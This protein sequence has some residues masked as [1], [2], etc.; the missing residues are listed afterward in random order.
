MTKSLIKDI[1]C[2]LDGKENELW[3]GL[4]RISNCLGV[5]AQHLKC[6]KEQ[7]AQYYVYNLGI[8]VVFMLLDTGQ[9]SD[10]DELAD[11]ECFHEE[12][13]LYF[14]SKSHRPSPVFKLWQK[15]QQCP[16]INGGTVLGV[17]LTNSY[18]INYD[19][20]VKVWDKMH[21]RVRHNLKQQPKELPC[22]NRRSNY[23]KLFLDVYRHKEESPVSDYNLYN[24]FTNTEKMDSTPI[25]D[26]DD[27]IEDSE[28]PDLVETVYSPNGEIKRRKIVPAATLLPP[29][30]NPTDCL[31]KL[32]GLNSLKDYIH[33]LTS[34]FNYQQK[35]AAFFP[36]QNSLLP[37]MTLHSV[38]LGNV[39]V[40][41]TTVAQIYSSL[42]H[43]QGL[44]SKGHTIV[45]SRS[46]FTSKV[47]GGEEFNVRSLLKLSQGGTL[48]IDEAYTLLSPDDRDPSNRIL[49]L[50]LEVLADENKRDLCV[51]LCGYATPLRRLI[52]SNLGLASRFPNVFVFEDFSLSDLI[53]IGKNRIEEAGYTFTK[54]GMMALSTYVEKMYMNR[55]STF[56]NARDIANL[57]EQILLRHAIRC[58]E[59][60]VDIP[61]F[62]LQITSAD[63]NAIS[64]NNE[65]LVLP[66]RRRVGFR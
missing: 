7:D 27:L 5:S 15:M 66:E 63:I 35:I 40:G 49:S 41:K 46:S 24:T 28:D 53:E 3:K 4:Q 58:V 44:L 54:G 39:G 55:S 9:S 1:S 59:E 51:V 61:Q 57:C 18:L 65:L 2:L 56:G 50:M 43:E 6:C 52:S 38:F 29:L 17:V 47:Y 22:N 21:I 37:K 14:T 23:I 8:Q 20:M 19:D 13:P 30:S 16:L 34:L 31:K 26:W 42:L 32:T 25:L 48:V 12:Q 45:C 62:L 33:K 36:N 60:N 10:L 11:E 64:T